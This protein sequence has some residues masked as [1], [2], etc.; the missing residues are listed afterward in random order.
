[1]QNNATVTDSFYH[2]HDI[3][4]KAGVTLMDTRGRGHSVARGVHISQRSG[5]YCHTHG[6][7]IHIGRECEIR[8][9]D[10]NEQATFLNMMGVSN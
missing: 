1:M 10:H 6:N 8:A 9:D 5:H 2:D 4:S 7:R 3:V